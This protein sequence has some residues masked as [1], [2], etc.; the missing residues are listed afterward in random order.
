MLIGMTGYAQH[1]K[2]TA[3]EKLVRDYG[4]QQFAFADALRSMAAALNP[5]VRTNDGI[6]EYDYRYT[7]AI[8][9]LGYEEAK[10]L[11]ELRRILQVLGTEVMRDLFGQDVWVNLLERELRL[12]EVID[13]DGYGTFNGP[14][15]GVIT[16]VRFHNEAAL[17]QRLG[18]K[19]IRVRRVV[20]LNGLGELTDFDNGMSKDHPSEAHIENLPVDYDIEAL[21][22]EDLEK[23]IGTIA[24]YELKLGAFSESKA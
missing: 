17:V 9:E 18:G 14:N 4:F 21:N 15:H 20:E 23:N 19:M 11:P 7:E 12:A 3:G 24:D 2:N 1:G 22:V 5:I 16:D 13:D 10:K 6:A 8:N